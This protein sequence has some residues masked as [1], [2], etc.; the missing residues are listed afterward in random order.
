MISKCHLE[1]SVPSNT[2]C[3]DYKNIENYEEAVNSPEMWECHHRAET[4]FSDGTEYPSQVSL[5]KEEL[6]AL[7]M[8]YNRPASEFIF[9]TNFDHSQ[10]HSKHKKRTKEWYDKVWATRRARGHVGHSEEFKKRNSEIK[11]KARWWNNGSINKFCEVCPEN[12]VAGRIKWANK[13]G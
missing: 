7:G 1:K 2:F 3:T 9:M 4:H 6:I 11:K 12:F 10:L 13:R 5:S 8:Y